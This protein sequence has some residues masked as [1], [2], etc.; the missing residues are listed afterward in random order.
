MSKAPIEPG[1]LQVFRWFAI[2]RLILLAAA[3]LLQSFL[4]F[5]RALPLRET[6]PLLYN[7]FVVFEVC[8]LLGYLSWE[9]LKLK[10]GRFY[11]P[12]GICLAA[13][14]LLFELSPLTAIPRVWQ[15][16]VLLFVLII[17]VAWQYDF[18][19]VVIFTLAVSWINLGIS[20]GMP[21][22]FLVIEDVFISNSIFLYGR[23]LAR[24]VSFL[25][26][27]YVVTRLVTAQREQQRE[28]A[29]ANRKLVLHAATLEQLTISRERNRLSR[30]LH[31]TLAHTL[32]ALAVQFE[33]VMAVWNP[34]PEKVQG[35]LVQMQ[36]ST[37]SGLDETRRS[38]KALRASPLEDLGLAQS[39]QLLAV[40]F[41][42]RHNLKLETEIAENIDDI[43]PEV[44]QCFYRV[45]QEALE[46]TARHAQ[47][48]TVRVVMSQTN[49]SMRLLVSDDG[50]G[51]DE[52]DL[53]NPDGLGIQGMRE[54][55]DL[56]GAALSIESQ[57][58]GGTTVRLQK[59]SA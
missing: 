44:E 3:L 56:V 19:S 2:L 18:R 59:E 50:I 29:A 12:I 7:L 11:L 42:E 43:S 20:L 1:V 15:P 37:R 38:L 25:I 55:A 48:Q 35:V 5:E 51:F 47:A 28:L 54:R 8:A 36:A 57:P 14:G 30:E 21:Q 4:P 23:L 31:D 32:S 52:K 39:L 10:M 49:G 17:L 13:A 22:P 24:G 27:G 16:D 33:A 41:A 45:A 9:W 6:S 46:N 34:I 53:Q 40:D 58:G 26:I